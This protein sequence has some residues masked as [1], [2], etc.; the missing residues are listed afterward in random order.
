MF[1]PTCTPLAHGARFKQPQLA[2]SLHKLARDG[3][4]SFYEGELAQ[5]VL[6]GLTAL[7]VPISAKDLAET[8]ARLEAPLRQTYRTLT[9]LA[10]PPPTQGITTLQIMGI[11]NALDIS[12]VKRNSAEHIHR[13][14]EAVKHA[15]RDRKMLADPDFADP[16]I[17][18]CLQPDYLTEHAGQITERAA[19]WPDVFQ[20]ADTVYF[21]VVDDQGRCASC[22]QSTYLDR[23][24]GV[25]VG[26]TGIIWQ[27]RGSAF[28][29]DPKHP[30]M[31]A[32]GKRPFYTLNPGIALNNGRPHLLYGTQGA[33]GQ[34]QTLAMLLTH[35]IDYGAD[36]C[37][38][39]TSPRFLLGRTFS[40]ATDNLKI[41]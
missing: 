16:K 7:G 25:V 15:F 4:R 29:T 17:D 5:D 13:V 39:M 18:Q 22:L 27:N 32:P 37:S 20:P 41:E 28:S 2:A 1:K 19:P 6:A 9:L 30:S 24:S 23:G 36:A 40:D 8:K 31:I 14:A 21:A 3:F 33:D 26:D 38:T 12:D 10:P 35:L 11:L 34:P